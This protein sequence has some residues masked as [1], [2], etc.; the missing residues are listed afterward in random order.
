[1][2]AAIARIL[3]YFR[4]SELRTA[5]G[6]FHPAVRGFAFPLPRWSVDNIS[7]LSNCPASIAC[8]PPCPRVHAR[9]DSLFRSRDASSAQLGHC[10]DARERVRRQCARHQLGRPHMLYKARLILAPARDTRLPVPEPDCLQACRLNP[11]RRE[12]PCTATTHSV[13]RV[14]CLLPPYALHGARCTADLLRL[15][16][17]VPANT[18]KRR[19]R[20]CGPTCATPK[21]G[22]SVP[23]PPCRRARPASAER[24]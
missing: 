15:R 22:C 9:I 7:G 24:L 6:E 16:A 12:Q 17:F 11:L 13:L 2:P 20:C 4:K 18:K 3:F 10:G 19:D 23:R 8:L 14:R 1:M 5:C 21:S